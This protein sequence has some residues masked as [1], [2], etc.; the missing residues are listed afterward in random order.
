M[1]SELEQKYAAIAAQMNT[2][3]QE[4]EVDEDDMDFNEDENYVFDHLYEAQEH[5]EAILEN[6]D[7]L[8]ELRE[9]FKLMFP[10]ETDGLMLAVLTETVALAL[11]VPTNVA[12]LLSLYVAT[13][14]LNEPLVAL[15]NCANKVVFATVTVEDVE[16]IKPLFVHELQEPLFIRHLQRW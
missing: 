5:L 3:F 2:S 9:K 7:N 11:F 10:N 14:I 1:N 12:Y 8:D 15:G 16:A 4:I 13:S 6:I